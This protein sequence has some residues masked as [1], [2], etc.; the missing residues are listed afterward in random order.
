MSNNDRA[1]HLDSSQEGRL[2]WEFFRA[3]DY[4][5]PKL[6]SWLAWVGPPSHLRRN[7]PLQLHQ[8]REP[9]RINTL[10]RWFIIG[11]PVE[12]SI[13]RAHIPEEILELL[14]KSGL[15]V[16]E[17]GSLVPSVLLL[18]VGDILTA[19]D[20]APTSQPRPDLVISPGPPTQ[21]L[22]FFTIGRKVR[23]ALD[24]CCGPGIHAM[25]MASQSENVT[26]ADLNP[27]ALHLARFNARINGLEPI[28]FVQG[29]LFTP[30][31]G[32]RFDLIVSNPPFFML[33][34]NEI[35]YRD[36]PLELDSFV[37]RM[38]RQAPQ[39]LNEGGF[40]QIIFEWVEIKGQPWKERLA[41]WVSGTGCDVWLI[42]DNSQRPLEYSFAKMHTV[43]Q[44]SVEKDVATLAAWTEHYSCHNVAAMHG[45]IMAMRKRSGAS[46][47]VEMEEYTIDAKSEFGELV[48]AVFDGHDFVEK[49][50]DDA[51]L[52]LRPR[53]APHLRLE[54]VLRA[55]ENGWEATSIELKLDRGLQLSCRLDGRV[56]GF[57][58]GCTGKQSLGEL[59]EPILP[60]DASRAEVQAVCIRV[61]R[62][63][64]QRGFLLTG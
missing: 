3:S 38:V 40:F 27:R 6:A 26:A 46:N 20:C 56:A 49:A 1:I 10:V 22:S 61:V 11:Y 7:L 28:E 15:L 18:P 34:A 53:R 48:E 19:C 9:S 43:D 24:L 41:G 58:S 32:R 50:D 8:T 62:R 51:M 52:A 36:N 64:I 21:L 14:T 12:D 29:D 57:L 30:F 5:R 63:L 35:L 39:F 37:E 47:W 2:L 59:I 16:A 31:K 45:G 33:P 55:T 25:K 23:S 42:K 44:V 60:N 17:N 54:H 4:T 13:A